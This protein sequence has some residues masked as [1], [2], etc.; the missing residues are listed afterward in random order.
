M[1]FYWFDKTEPTKGVL[2][3]YTLIRG[4]DWFLEDEKSYEI[5]SQDC[6]P[7]TQIICIQTL[8]RPKDWLGQAYLETT[9]GSMKILK[10]DGQGVLFWRNGWRGV[11]WFGSG[12]WSDVERWMNIP[13]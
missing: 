13:L 1:W 3:P 10:E 6:V 5:L 2:R 11:H 8:L 7:E 9:E 12:S 4:S